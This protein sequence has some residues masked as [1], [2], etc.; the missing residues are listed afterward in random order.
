M[1]S[2]CSKYQKQ[3]PRL[4]LCELTA[5]EEKALGDHLEICSQCRSEHESYSQTIRMLQSVENEPVPRHFFVYE[6]AQK[7]NPWQIFRQMEPFW[8]TATVA[9]A[10][11]FLFIG[12]AAV[13]QMNVKADRNGLAVAFGHKNMDTTTLKTEI[14]K[15]AEERNRAAAQKWVQEIRAELDRSRTELTHQQK[16]ELTAAFAQLN[17][18]LSGRILQEADTVRIDTGALISDMYKTVSQQRARDLA[19]I[20]AH[21]ENTKELSA[22]KEHQTN[23]ILDALLQVAELKLK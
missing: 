21:F 7:Q 2:Q 12:I 3:I 23:E 11:L 16:E 19:L 6:G 14:L 13:S 18:R 17:S 5:E 1:K 8:Q 9:L 10:G 4:I 20:N 22:V 15:I